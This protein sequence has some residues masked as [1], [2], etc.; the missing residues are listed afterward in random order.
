[1]EPPDIWGVPEKKRSQNLPLDWKFWEPKRSKLINHSLLILLFYRATRFQISLSF[2]PL[3]PFVLCRPQHHPKSAA[4]CV[5]RGTWL[6]GRKMSSSPLAFRTYRRRSQTE[7]SFPLYSGFRPPCSPASVVFFFF[8]SFLFL[9]PPIFQ[10]C[11]V[12]RDG[13]L[14]FSFVSFVYCF[15][16][17]DYRVEIKEGPFRAEGVLPPPPPRPQPLFFFWLS[18]SPSS[19][20]RF[21]SLSF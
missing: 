18:R 6:I 11:F 3:C 19:S 8:T 2:P 5:L 9:F 17:K 16:V 20:L 12:L 15:V 10:S 4:V 7:S 1:M 13:E 21:P 14:L